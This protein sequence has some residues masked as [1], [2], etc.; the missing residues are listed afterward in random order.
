MDTINTSSVSRRG[1]SATVTHNTLPRS[2]DN[3]DSDSE[4]ESSQTGD[5][6]VTRYSLIFTWQTTLPSKQIIAHLSDYLQD[7]NPTVR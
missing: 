6:L 5:T 7:C 3:S 4:T 1:S 2:A